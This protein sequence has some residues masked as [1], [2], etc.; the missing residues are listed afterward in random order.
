ME[1]FIFCGVRGSLG[2]NKNLK[3]SLQKNS[4]TLNK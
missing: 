1:N 2:L 4:N 3:T